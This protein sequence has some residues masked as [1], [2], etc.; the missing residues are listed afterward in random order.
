MANAK[1]I[2]LFGADEYSM[3]FP[4]LQIMAEYSF[5]VKVRC[6]DIT[7]PLK[8]KSDS[9]FNIFERTVLRLVRLG[10]ND[11]N[12]IADTM[13]ISKDLASFLMS[14]LTELGK[15]NANG[16]ITADGIAFLEGAAT[17]DNYEMVHGMVMTLEETGE[18]LPIVLTDDKC[19][20]APAYIDK[21]VITIEKGSAGNRKHI[22]GNIVTSKGG[23]SVRLSQNQLRQTV[24]AYNGIIRLEGNRTLSL[25]KGYMIEVSSSGISAYLHVKAAVQRGNVEYFLCSEGIV[26]NNDMIGSIINKDAEV[27]AFLMSRAAVTGDSTE[28]SEN[29]T[30]R[31]P[32]IESN[33]PEEIIDVNNF[34]ERK[35]NISTIK[36]NVCRLF[37]TVE[38]A[39]NYHL[40]S[41]WPSHGVLEMFRTQSC[42]EN[43]T[44]LTNYLLQLGIAPQQINSRVISMMDCTALD[45]YITTKTPNIYVVFPL[46][47]AQAAED[48]TSPIRSLFS[49]MP[50]VM[51]YL[52]ELTKYA[53]EFRHGGE[54]KS[55]VSKDNYSQLYEKTAQLVSLV[56]PDARFGETKNSGSSV[57]ERRAR[58]L[59]ALYRDVGIVFHTLEPQA[60]NELLKTS[61]D[62]SPSELPI[63]SEAVLS[64]C[65]VIETVLRTCCASIENALV[66]DKAA[67]LAKLE[68]FTGEPASA[69]FAKVSEHYIM[70]VARGGH[71]SLGAL[72]LMYILNEKDE[73]V[74]LFVEKGFHTLIAELATKRAHGNDVTLSLSTEKIS[75]IRA[76]VYELIKFLGGNHER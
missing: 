2:D 17:A 58:G 49:E 51:K 54:Q 72:A 34:D 20:F 28:K 65:K 73:T 61:S 7:L 74:R 35:D 53:A 6:Y 41:Y 21:M 8:T 5:F 57:S 1:V 23:S 50:D 48:R 45:R 32:E 19:D 13:C 47:L 60:Q 62:K 66:A 12:V 75:E 24:N 44:V 42:I 59:S 29:R 69:A 25:A 38:H 68:S 16:T 31:Y 27:R 64:F 36:S 70:N 15:L 4:Q 71:A 11:V 37:Q 14:R 22:S 52:A 63:P 55:V 39:F 18:L 43:E 3:R 9:E 10:M 26:I 67:A 46:A 30:Y 76:K 56:L 40:R 33:M